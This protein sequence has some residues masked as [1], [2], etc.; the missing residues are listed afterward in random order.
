VLGL[1][2]LVGMGI[3]A[4]WRKHSTVTVLFV[5]TAVIAI[6]IAL[7]GVGDIFALAGFREPQ[8]FV[9]LVALAFAL[10][11]GFGVSAL[12]ARA[13]KWGTCMLGLALVAI[14]VLPALLTPTM[15]WGF[16]SQL[17]PRQYPADWYV[18]NDKL[19]QDTDNFGVLSLPWH[20][21]MSYPFAGR[22]IVNPSQAFFDKPTIVSN[23]LEFKNA[24]PTFPDAK[25][26]VL[27]TQLLQ[28]AATNPHLGKS[29][30]ELGIK[31]ILLAKTFDYQN[32]DYLDN[33]SDLQLLA[34][35]PN[36]RLYRNNA[37]GQ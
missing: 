11:A 10:F 16:S 1:W 17:S 31:Y 5:S 2:I 33:Q 25:K 19:N 13:Q 4:L 27:S 18:I 21:Y 35:T 37:Y 23:E 22:V 15:V 34:D 6:I 26:T 8:K 7:V 12:F 9:G 32:Y 20:L 36:L 14:L 28:Q 30:N 29:L 24:S 3:R